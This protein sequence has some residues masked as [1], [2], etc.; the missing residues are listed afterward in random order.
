LT[1][2]IVD[3]ALRGRT[4]FVTG[5]SRN[6]GRAICVAL[7]QAGANVAISAHSAGGEAEE[8]AALV[9]AAGSRAIVKLGD[10]ANPDDVGRMLEEVQTALG[11]I[12]ILVSNASRRPKAHFLDLTIEDWDAIIRSN[13]SASFYLSRLVLG[14]M[15]ERGWGRIILVGGPDG[16]RPELYNG[17]ASRAHCNTAKAGLL[18]LMKAIAMEFGRD[19]VT[20]NAVIPGIM[21]TTRDPVNY[22][23]W[24]MPEEELQRRLA[25]PRLGEPDEVADMCAFLASDGAAYVSGQTLHVSGGYLTP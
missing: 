25:V 21:N 4:A 2:I 15:R 7:A 8:T 6:L 13:L 12:D 5:G 11:P 3:T 18:G 10:V 1:R 9:R 17:A 19:G 20:S 14:G 16:Q 24:P 23:H 22:P